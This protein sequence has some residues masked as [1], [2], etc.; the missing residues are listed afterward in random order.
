M[1]TIELDEQCKSCA[2]TGLYQGMAERDGFAVICHT[3][4]GTGCY[5]FVYQYEDFS[6]RIEGPTIIRVLETNPGISIGLDKEGK[7][8]FES[9][10]GMPY[11]DWKNG[12]P[13]PPKSEM[14]DFTC[15]SWWCQSADKKK[16]DW[17]ECFGTLGSSFSSCPSFPTK[18]KCWKRFDE[19]EELERLRDRHKRHAEPTSK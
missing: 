10:G 4:K 8:T 18:E 2:G 12:L 11:Q 16:P 9:F 5:H 15:P 6:E 3:C 17:E 13:F 19:K 7:Y 14:R 1:K